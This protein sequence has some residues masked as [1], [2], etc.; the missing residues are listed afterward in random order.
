MVK[1][2]RNL[3]CPFGRPIR[4]RRPKNTTRASQQL[5]AMEAA[6]ATWAIE[7]CDRLQE[8]LEGNQ[9]PQPAAP[10]PNI[11]VDLD[12][13]HNYLDP[14]LQGPLEPNPEA[15]GA[16]ETHQQLISSSHYKRKRLRDEENWRRVSGPMFRAYMLCAEQTSDWGNVTTW[17]EDRNQ[18]CSCTPARKHNQTLDVV[19]ILCM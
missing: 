1:H 14:L 3:C 8:A 15:P 18:E 10:I 19:D 9:P 12:A 5:A 6:E 2:E 4:K 16:A 11:D 17:N 13:D 7:R